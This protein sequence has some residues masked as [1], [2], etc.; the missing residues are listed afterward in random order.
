MACVCVGFA[1]LCGYRIEV[2]RRRKQPSCFNWACD[3]VLVSTLLTWMWLSDGAVCVQNE[4]RVQ[5]NEEIVPALGK[6]GRYG[7]SITRYMI[8]DRRRV[9]RANLV[10]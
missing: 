1:G 3:D 7:C 6:R 8:S 5:G 2:E 10:P 9:L 4:A